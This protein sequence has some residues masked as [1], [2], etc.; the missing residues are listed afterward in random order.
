MNPHLKKFKI[1]T[2][3][4][5]EDRIENLLEGTLY[6][7]EAFKFIELLLT[8]DTNRFDY[9][10]T[11]GFKGFSH[12]KEGQNMFKD[13]ELEMTSEQELR[14]VVEFFNNSVKY[15]EI[16]NIQELTS[17]SLKIQLKG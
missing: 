7:R 8:L 4:I 13:I 9:K 12:F 3:W 2:T 11:S 17:T 15:S 14:N 6:L 16:F 1:L 10:L 5:T